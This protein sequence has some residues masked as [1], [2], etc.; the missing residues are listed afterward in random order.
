MVF[1]AL[2]PLA[3]QVAGSY[4]ISVFLVNSV[5]IIQPITQITFTFVS[6]W[7]Y[8]NFSTISVVRVAVLILLLGTVVRLG[9]VVT[10]DFWPVFVGQLIASCSTPFFINVQTIIANTW[11][12]DNE[13]ALAGAVQMVAMPL[14]SAAQYVLTGLLFREKTDDFNFKK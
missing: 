3:V 10:G 6:I 2:M 5:S 12:G 13:R 9:C 7:M 4:G 14:G 8:D 1:I 11:F